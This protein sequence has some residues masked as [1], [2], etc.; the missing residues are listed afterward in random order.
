MNPKSFQ[1]RLEE[2]AA[3]KRSN[4]K[5]DAKERQS[6]NWRDYS[7]KIAINILREMRS[8]NITKEKLAQLIDVSPDF[9]N[10]VVKGK[11]NLSLETITKI[12]ETLNINLINIPEK[13]N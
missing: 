5:N 12:E 11:E 1:Q 7:F 2:K 10:N 4:W 3:K 13:N 8:Q 9:M 6:N